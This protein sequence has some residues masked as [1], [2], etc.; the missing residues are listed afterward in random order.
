MINEEDVINYYCNI[1]QE[2]LNQKHI[3]NCDEVAKAA[4]KF[5]SLQKVHR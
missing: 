5:Q 3:W 1:L 2:E 4:T